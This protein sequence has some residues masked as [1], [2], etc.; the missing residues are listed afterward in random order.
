MGVAS[1][2][3]EIALAFFDPPKAHPGTRANGLHAV[4]GRPIFYFSTA[5]GPLVASTSSTPPH[6][7]ALSRE[8]G[9]L[10]SRP[11]VALSTGAAA[12]TI[13]PHKENA[14]GRTATTLGGTP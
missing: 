1:E 11:V 6:S 8:G 12:K 9:R 5:P 3:S 10:V 2:T 14:M 4:I 13:T 7:W